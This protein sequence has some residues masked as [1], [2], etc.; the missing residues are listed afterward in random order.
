M[1]WPF[2]FLVLQVSTLLSVKEG[3]LSLHTSLL[4]DGKTQSDCEI[5]ASDL[6]VSAQIKEKRRLCWAEAGNYVT[7][8]GRA[9][10]G[11]VRCSELTTVVAQIRHFLSRNVEDLKNL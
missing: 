2:E 3:A 9:T 8:L 1:K 6:Y 7:L 5:S 4:T 10:G 11:A